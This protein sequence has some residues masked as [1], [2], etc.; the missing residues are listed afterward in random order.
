MADRSNPHRWL[1]AW[2]FGFEL[3]PFPKCTTHVDAS[4]QS[5]FLEALHLTRPVNSSGSLTEGV[6]LYQQIYSQIRSNDTLCGQGFEGNS[7]LYGLE[8][9][10]GLYIQWTTAPV[11]NNLLPEGWSIFESFTS[12]IR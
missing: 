8:Q 3:V 1:P 11:I 5:L 7:D 12:Y 6:V 10:L 9:R 4:Q 2:I